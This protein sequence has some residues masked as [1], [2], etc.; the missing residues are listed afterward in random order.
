MADTDRTLLKKQEAG[1]L[2]A[3]NP[4]VDA[5]AAGGGV[6]E[7][8]SFVLEYSK[9]ADDAMA[10]TTTTEVGTGMYLPVK[11]K[12]TGAWL[13]LTGATTLTG[14]ASNYA[15]ILVDKYSSAGAGNANLISFASSTATTDDLAV[16]TPHSIFGDAVAAQ[17]V[18]D[19]GSNFSFQITKAAS[20]VVVPALKLILRFEAV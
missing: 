11:A 5:L 1:A 9:A 18:C 12:L 14:H 20:G 19:A 10:S 16:Y 3:L 17:L 15:T 6:A 7:A 8:H 4:A 13:L 2:N